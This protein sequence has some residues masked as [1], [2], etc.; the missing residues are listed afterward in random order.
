MTVGIN[1]GA[2]GRSGEITQ[3]RR[4]AKTQRKRKI[5]YFSFS[6]LYLVV[7]IGAPALHRQNNKNND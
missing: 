7:S 4:V 5:S 6:N 1:A 2:L 3:R